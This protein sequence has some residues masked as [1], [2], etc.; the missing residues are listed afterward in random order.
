MPS[1]SLPDKVGAELLKWV[2]KLTDFYK[3]ENKSAMELDWP[4]GIGVY[5]VRG[6]VWMWC[7]LG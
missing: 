1:I 3:S 5:V 7:T 6:K 4:S 2:M